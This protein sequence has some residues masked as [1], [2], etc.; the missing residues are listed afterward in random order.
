M[1]LRIETKV[2][3]SCWAG[4][5]DVA[6]FAVWSF[7]FCRRGLRLASG[8][9]DVGLARMLAAAGTQL[10]RLLLLQMLN[11]KKVAARRGG[12]LR[13]SSYR[14]AAKKTSVSSFVPVF[15]CV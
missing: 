11:Q 15:S 2:A 13:L 3:A 4:G 7:V 9:S 5:V 1:F 6:F 8:C 10:F 12:V 14:R